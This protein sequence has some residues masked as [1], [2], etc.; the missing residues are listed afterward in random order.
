MIYTNRQTRYACRRSTWR[1]VQISCL[2]LAFAGVRTTAY[3][4][5]GAA[6]SPSQTLLNAQHDEA[7]WIPPAK[8][9]SGDRFT[10][11]TKTNVSNL[12][13]VWRTDIADDGRQKASPVIWNGTMYLSPPHE[14]VL[15]LDASDGKLRRQTLYKPKYILLDAVNRGVGPAGGK[16]LVATQDCTLVPIG[17]K[18]GNFVLPDRKLGKLVHRQALS[19]QTELDSQPSLD[20]A[21]ARPNHGDGIEWNGGSYDPNG[22]SFLVPSTAKC[23]RSHLNAAQP[24]SVVTQTMPPIAPGSMST[25]KRS[26]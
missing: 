23:V 17:Y 24:R 16:V 13:L 6:R 15:A 2:V 8:T 5:R 20:G 19:D 3:G 14:G 7:D 1:L 4:Q 26:A 21:K 18:A 25:A 11:F 10:Q 12:R 22:N 9:Y